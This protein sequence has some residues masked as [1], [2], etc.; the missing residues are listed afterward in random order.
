MSPEE[1][2]A[3]ASARER[4]PPRR[5][6]RR[7][8]IWGSILLI[9][10]IIV[11]VAVVLTQNGDP[12]REQMMGQIKSALDKE[13]VPANDLNNAGHYQGKAFN[14]LYEQNANINSMDRTQA[15]Q[16]FALA[17]LYFSSNGISTLY[18]PSPPSWKSETNWLTDLNEC[19]WKG[20]QC[21]DRM[22]V[23]GIALESNHLTGKIPAELV[24][25]RDHL[26]TLDFTT[27]LL[28]M[29]EA[30]FYFLEKLPKLT[31]I[32]M[33][34][35]YISS[36]NGIPS[37][38]GHCTQLEMLRLSYN[39]I[40]GKLDATMFRKLSKL[41]HLEVESNFLTGGIPTAI[42]ELSNLVYMYMRRNSLKFNLNWLKSGK[43]ANLCK[44]SIDGSL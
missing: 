6:R 36:D 22:K 27:N 33:D 21:T 13:G 34:D 38:M 18:T 40:G 37:F 42:G 16:R 12:E 3:Q 14:W 24:L 4:D 25:L 35:N 28:Y 17:C 23:D 11:V 9:V 26:V 15:L 2:M 1:I 5:R 32:L 31:T 20:V 19:Q 44:C 7:W 41:T 30:D 43:M 10:V 8:L 29:E 39:L